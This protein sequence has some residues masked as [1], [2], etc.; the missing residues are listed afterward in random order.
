MNT[1]HHNPNGLPSEIELI[2]RLAVLVVGRFICILSRET[3][4]N[5]ACIMKNIFA[6]VVGLAWFCPSFDASAAD[7]ALKLADKAPPKDLDPSITAKLQP[8]A[9]Q[10]LD[11]GKAVYE[12]WLVAELLLKATPDSPAKA[13]D[14]IREAALLGV[15]AVAE[16]QRD[17]RDDELASGVY[18]MRFALQPQDGNHLGTAEFNYFAVLVPAKLDRSP[19]GITDYKKLVRIS[20][21]ET[22]SGHPLIIS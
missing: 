15:V 16:P 12:F 14:Q 9:I 19:D 8:K 10:L 11:S 7:L 13:L 22:A 1:E 3:A 6:L 2:L 20:G 18:T 5:A 21:R 17:Y 4:M